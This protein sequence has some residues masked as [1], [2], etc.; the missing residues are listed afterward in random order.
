MTEWEILGIAPTTDSS[1]LKAGY[2]A[3]LKRWKLSPAE[4]TLDEIKHAYQQLLA[5]L[6][7]DSATAGGILPL[8]HPEPLKEA[9]EPSIAE[10]ASSELTAV[11]VAIAKVAQN[12]EESEFDQATW[13]SVSALLDVESLNTLATRPLLEGELC[14]L[15]FEHPPGWHFFGYVVELFDWNETNPF[16]PEQ[17]AYRNAYDVLWHQLVDRPREAQKLLSEHCYRIVELAGQDDQLPDTVAAL[18]F[19]WDDEDLANILGSGEIHSTLLRELDRVF[20]LDEEILLAI[21]NYY[22]WDDYE[23]ED[24]KDAVGARYHAIYR[25][26]SQG[27]YL[28]VLNQL[29]N[30]AAPAELEEVHYCHA[31]LIAKKM[32]RYEQRFPVEMKV[33]LEELRK[34]FAG[35]NPNTKVK[36]DKW[37][38]RATGDSQIA[39]YLAIAVA[40]WFVLIAIFTVLDSME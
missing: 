33:T 28:Y 27:G 25:R 32:S 37:V 11:R 20:D 18:N 30:A 24:I 40:F 38:R 6:S 26:S 21:A 7:G 15:F 9:T 12:I 36:K 8:A 4:T 31:I 2:A 5:K 14:K 22:G 10:P 35:Y 19:L 39:Q 34:Q 23:T 13:D 16:P 3:A 17:D 1:A 29:R